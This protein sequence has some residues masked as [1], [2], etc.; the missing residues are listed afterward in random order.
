MAEP[1]L[2]LSRLH[3][4]LAQPRGMKRI[5]ALLATDD[6][7]AAVAGL[8]V[9]EVHQLVHEVGFADALELTN[10]CTPEQ[11]RGCVDLDGWD[12]DHFDLEHCK[13]WL[14]ALVE[15]GYEKVAEVWQELDPELTALFIA[16][17]CRVYDLSL[18]DEPADDDK[19]P[20]FTTPDTYFAIELMDTSDETMSLVHRLINDLYRADPNG[21]LA[22]HTLMSARSEPPAELEEMSYRWRSG[23]MADMGYVD[24]LEALQ[25]YQ[26][27]DPA[28]VRIAEHTEDRFGDAD[29]DEHPLGAD[30]LPV[31]VAER[32]IGVAFLSR[33]LDRIT[34][35]EEISR[36][37]MAI[38]VL[39]NKVLAAAR[40][41]PGDREAVPVAAEHAL[42]TLSLGLE[43]VSRGDLARAEQA[44]RTISLT[45]L[46]R[47]GHTLTL[48][49]ALVARRLA[50]RAVTAGPPMDQVL[51]AL[52][53]KRAFYPQVLDD[54][55][56]AD[57]RPFSSLAEL[58]TVAQAITELAVR[59]A[60]AETLGVDL[61]AMAARPEPRPALDDHV[62]TALVRFLLDGRL[63]PIPL[64]LADIVRFRREYCPDRTIDE[65][66]RAAA[67]RAL[68]MHLDE[69][70]VESAGA[71]L[72]ALFDGWMRDIE[73]ALGHLPDVPDPRFIDRV[74]V[75]YGS[76]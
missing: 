11:F 29:E 76:S 16:R 43:S 10:R 25:V 53:G 52:L 37:E 60:T 67:R 57:V 22:R 63:Q 75:A 44:L 48:R 34:E 8:A 21:V 58:R 5:D 31:P 73:D 69:H 55:P 38:V 9:S 49:L 12:H 54:P 17:T 39:T 2:P 61:L 65:P 71:F 26:P 20:I 66:S 13:P 6:P 27:I 36:L 4:R 7:D 46:H 45:R 74:L 50:P 41:S 35:P 42:S 72:P 28:S 56:A 14:A 3:A 59:V 32:V 19:R 24:S 33:A 40:I 68:E 47:V 30:T 62:R 15:S 51:A 23:R 70:Q 18:G 1:T 64:T